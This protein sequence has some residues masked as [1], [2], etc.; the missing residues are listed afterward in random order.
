MPYAIENVQLTSKNE[1]LSYLKKHEERSLF[2]LGNCEAH[3]FKLNE[4]PHSGNYKLIRDATGVVGVFCLTKRGNLIIQSDVH[5]AIYD[6]LL[7]AC[8]KEPIALSGLIGD[9]AFTSGFWNYL[10]D[11]KAIQK[12]SYSSKEILYS[13]DLQIEMSQPVE[14]ARLLTQNDYPQWKALRLAYIKELGYP[15]DLPEVEMQAQYARKTVQKISWG[16][17][18]DGQLV[19]VADFNAK[20]GDLAQVGGVYT[21]PAYRGKGMAKALFQK[22]LYDAKEKHHLK[23]LIIFTGEKNT[24]ARHLYESLPAK[25]IGHYGILFGHC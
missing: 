16:I 18:C 17:F 20:A 21:V 11:K 12:E 5:E 10:K 3:G 25:N 13:I 24:A 22:L 2:L 9:W 23:K 7:D 8:K 6:Q 19:S 4:A 14:E 15:G 1:M